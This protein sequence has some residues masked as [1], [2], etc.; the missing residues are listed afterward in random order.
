MNNIEDNRKMV[1]ALSMRDDDQ[2]PELFV[3]CECAEE[4]L[5]ISYYD[6]DKTFYVAFWGTGR[7]NVSLVPWRKRIR[8]IWKI[9]RGID[10][11]ADMVV[12][13]HKRAKQTADF[14]NEILDKAESSNNI[15]N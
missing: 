10:L 7:R 11:Y 12:L 4:A 3:K 5:E 8:M 14:I 9:L 2:I 15:D 13:D 1:T 6:D